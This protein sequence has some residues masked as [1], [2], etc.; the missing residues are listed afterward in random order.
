M[1]DVPAADELI[2]L[3]ETLNDYARELLPPR[4]T[5][6]RTK[7]SASES[8]VH[9]T[10]PANEGRPQAASIVDPIPFDHGSCTHDS[11]SETSPTSSV[12]SGRSSQPPIVVST[13]VSDTSSAY[14]KAKEQRP[15]RARLPS[16]ESTAGVAR[17]R[18]DLRAG[19]YIN[20][21]NGNILSPP[22]LKSNNQPSKTITIGRHTI[23]L[24]ST[25]FHFNNHQLKVG[26]RYDYTI[27]DM[28]YSALCEHED[29][30]DELEQILCSSHSWKWSGIPGWIITRDVVTML[31]KT[32][33]I[34]EE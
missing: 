5:S 22:I 9:L 29:K 30:L 3:T 15:N 25:D 14:R 17:E 26:S 11:M 28:F 31:P 1:D 12:T 20:D 6:R 10:V 2:K 33:G 23:K 24:S 18:L 34:Q 8:T 7:S 16:V 32:L 4:G 27:A 21:P 19:E 13:S